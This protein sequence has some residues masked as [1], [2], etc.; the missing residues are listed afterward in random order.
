MAAYIFVLHTLH[1]WS[2]MYVGMLS[3][4]R[5]QIVCV[6]AV[7]HVLF[8]L[9]TP[10]SILKEISDEVLLTSQNFVELCNQCASFL[11]YPFVN[12]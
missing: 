8:H 6:A 5:G 11:M 3:K 1:V 2:C 7:M 12:T 4:S 10:L 9:D